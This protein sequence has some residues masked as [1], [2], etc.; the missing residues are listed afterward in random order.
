MSMPFASRRRVL[1]G[2]LF[3]V[4]CACVAG[5]FAF[6]A[7]APPGTKYVC[8]PCGCDSDGKTFDAPGGCPSCGMILIP[9]QPDP[10]PANP[11]PPKAGRDAC[12]AAFVAGAKP[13]GGIS[14]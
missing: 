5:G 9:L 12:A 1:Q 7:E 11:T 3:G 2:G 8:P 14:Y 10:K 13:P 4:A 6:A